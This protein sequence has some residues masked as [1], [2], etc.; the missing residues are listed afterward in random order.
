MTRAVNCYC[1]FNFFFLYRV[2]LVIGGKKNRLCSLTQP[3]GLLFAMIFYI[4]FSLCRI[5]GILH[6]KQLFIGLYDIVFFLL[7]YLIRVE[8][9]QDKVCVFAEIVDNFDCY[10]ST[11]SRID[12]TPPGSCVRRSTIKY[13]RLATAR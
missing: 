1:Y 10:I 2:S 7:L 6:L 9:S 4:Y 3:N 11:I 12:Q 13:Y 5:L 8:N